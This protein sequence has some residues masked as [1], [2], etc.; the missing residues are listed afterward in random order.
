MFNPIRQRDRIGGSAENKLVAHST[1]RA[2]QLPSL[3]PPPLCV[4]HPHRRSRRGDGTGAP[5]HAADT[6][7]PR[8][9]DGGDAAEGGG[10]DGAAAT[11]DNEL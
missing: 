4:R 2:S 1:R 5:H 11:T 6:D 9:R 8:R 10:D 7:A 3:S